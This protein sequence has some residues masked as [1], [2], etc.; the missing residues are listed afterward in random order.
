MMKP[1]CNC[2]PPHPYPSPPQRGRGVG[3]RGEHHCLIRKR[4][5]KSVEYEQCRS[6]SRGPQ[7]P[8]S[9]PGEWRRMCS[10]IRSDD[11]P[12]RGDKRG[13]I[14]RGGKTMRSILL[15]ALLSLGVLAVTPELGGSKAQA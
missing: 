3:V 1:L 12:D 4:A 2:L 8:P 14:C 10:V 13:C 6:L 15:A 11:L 5:K 7:F 9:I